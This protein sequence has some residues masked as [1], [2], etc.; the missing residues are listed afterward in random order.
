MSFLLL[1]IEIA[2]IIYIVQ[3]CWNATFQILAFRSVSKAIYK[4]P[5]MNDDR[6]IDTTAKEVK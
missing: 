5:M 6:T 1:L 4:L 3:F 2:L